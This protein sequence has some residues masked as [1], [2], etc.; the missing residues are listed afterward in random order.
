MEGLDFTAVD[1]DADV[2]VDVDVDVCGEIACERVD[3]ASAA[4]SLA[5]ATA[6]A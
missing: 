2:D 5:F 1:V 4:I 3:F 6:N